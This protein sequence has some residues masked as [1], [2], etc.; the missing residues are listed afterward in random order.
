MKQTSR[1]IA[2]EHRVHGAAVDL[3]Q[4][5]L[6]EQVRVLELGLVRQRQPVGEED[7]GARF[8]VDSG[9]PVVEENLAD[10]LRRDQVDEAGQLV[11]L[12]RRD[13]L[14]CAAAGRGW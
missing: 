7:Q 1:E 10:V 3:F 12:G 4:G 6:L 8:Q 5:H 2:H 11:A 9:Q 13:V 14:R